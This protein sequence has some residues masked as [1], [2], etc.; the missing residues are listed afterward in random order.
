MKI[1]TAGDSFSFKAN[2][3]QIDSNP[4]TVSLNINRIN[5]APVAQAGPDQTVF[6]GDTV[7]LDGSGSGDV[8]KDTLNF[9]W[10]FAVTPAGS[11]AALSDPSVVNP[12]FIPDIAD[13]YEIQLIV[14]DG[15]VD[16]SPDKVIINAEPR[17][18]AVP[19][20]V[21][22]TQPAAEAAILAAN[23]KVGTINT[24]HSETVPEGQVISQNPAEGTSVVEDSTVNLTI[25]L[26]SVNQ[27]PFVSFSAS[28]SAIAQGESSAL[29]WSSL[30]GE[31]A[32]IDNDIGAVS[33]EGTTLVSPE[34]TTTFTLTV[35]GPAGSAN[36]Q[37]TV[38]VT[39]NPEPQPEGSYGE[40][41][42]DLVPADATV[43]QYDP[44]RFSLIT[45]LVH[46]INQ[47]SLPGVT[48]TV[49]SHAEYG[50]VT[51]DDEGRFSI[52][53]EGGGTLTVAYQK[54]GLLAAQRKVYVPWND[55]AIA[56][57]VVMIT[58]DPVATT[59]T[60][61]GNADTVVTHKSEDVVDAAGTRAVTMVFTGDN[62]AYLVDEQGNDV[63][64]LTTITTRA[65]E[66][67]TPE[68]MPAVLPPT[69]AFT[70]CAELSVDGAQRVR[71]DKPVTTFIDNF[72]GF[73]VGS[74]VPVGYYDRDKGV[75]VPSE[76]GVVVELLDA[77]SDGAVDALDADGDRQPDDLDD[78]GSFVSEVK[79]LG[80]SQ[81]YAPGAT[82]WR[83]ATTHFTPFDCNWPGGPPQDAIASNANGFP[84][85]DTQDGNGTDP[86]RH[87]CSFVEEKSR[88]F[89]EDISIPA[90]I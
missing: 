13:T 51:T 56:E 72:L 80:D 2:D 3:G 14:N 18:V 29:T 31:S 82:F 6:V 64:Q 26:G 62:T 78:D 67:P 50:S 43:D 40:Q 49:H 45:G 5:D 12:T 61:D 8:D 70:Y 25:S 19:D 27:P 37:V 84:Q 59:L 74:I 7:T 66:Y 39:G 87:I 28:P 85:A 32:H 15:T 36:A 34:S 77:D 21:G 48:I 79:G 68:S 86:K 69:S 88:I 20:L 17:R 46:D 4:A 10:S 42:E 54:Q 60:F 71:F 35:T 22:M 24:E 44:K 55:N 11:S 57:T 47:L 65:T 90:Q 73:P 23:L 63:Q 53:V 76:N 38:Q 58:E 30:R 33:V 75:W 16:S 41:Y 81:R 9:S 52:P 1:T 83:V 89:H